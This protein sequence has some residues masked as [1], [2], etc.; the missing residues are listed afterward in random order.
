VGR[1]LGLNNLKE[2]GPNFIGTKYF[3][4]I[5]QEKAVIEAHKVNNF[6]IEGILE[7]LNPLIVV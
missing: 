6:G 7:K 5:S 2:I 1:G 4:Q 3:L